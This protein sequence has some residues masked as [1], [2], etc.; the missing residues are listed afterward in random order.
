VTIQTDIKQ[1]LRQMLAVMEQERQA[2]AAMDLQSIVECAASK[3]ALG[4]RLQAAANDDLDEES[5]SLIDAARRLNEV[6]RQVR[7]LVAANVSARLDALT[8]AASVY[9][10]QG[11][12]GSHR[13]VAANPRA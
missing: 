5:L 13:P 9:R 4:D 7:N 10:A 8:G 1:S 2:L 6:N 11:T 3:S 12:R